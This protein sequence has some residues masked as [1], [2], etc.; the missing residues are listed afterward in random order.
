[1]PTM[2]DFRS[3]IAAAFSDAKNA[4]QT[5]ITLKS[6]DVHRQLG[7]YPSSNHQMPS[8]CNAMIE[9]TKAGD[10]ILHQ[11]PKGKGATLTIKY[12]IPR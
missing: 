7:G 8:C 10:D 5:S 2:D 9:A 12:R 4:G 11:P 1:M 3:F 6:G